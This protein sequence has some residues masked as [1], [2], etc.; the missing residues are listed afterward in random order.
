MRSSSVFALAVL[1]FAAPA[2]AQ[3]V[4]VLEIDG[5]PQGKLR[6]QIENALKLAAVVELVPLKTYRDAAAKKKVRLSLAMSPAGVARVSRVVK[7]DAAVGGE[8]TD[9]TYKVLISDR[10][11][12][13]LWTKELPV[14]KGVLSDDFAN[15]LARAIAA[16][17]EQGAARTTGG[18]EETNGGGEEQA[19][20][21]LTKTD[22]AGEAG[23]A[24]GGTS[25]GASDTGSG[26][27]GEERDSDL[28]DPNRRKQ[29][30]RVP[31]K[32][33]R[34]SLAGT[35]TWRSQCLRPGVTNCKEYDLAQVPPTGISIDFTATVPYLGLSIGAELFPLALLDNRILQGFGLLVGFMYGQS[36][37][38][39]VEESSQGQSAGQTVKSDDLAFSMQLAWRYHFQMGYGDP[40]PVGWVGLRGGTQSRS[41]LIDPTAGTSLPSSDR[42]FPTGLGFAQFGIDAS[43]PLN[44]YIRLEAAFSY[45]VNPRPAAEQI[46]GYG[47]LN[48]PTGGATATGFGIEAGVAGELWG[49]LGYTLRWRAMSFADRYYGQGQKW[50][51]CNEQQCGGV[52]EESFHS[53]LWGVTASF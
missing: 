49:P 45:Y 36:Q 15:K 25:T 13:Q 10:A 41:F 19:G 22:G 11:G 34:F 24:T 17:A 29:G 16:A 18:T 31:V 2:M 4:V 53:I 42:V 28:E 21:D 1:L 7:L 52:G 23:V 38:R 9:S 5:D 48:D 12:E 33:V 39:I 35:T 51:V 8:V 20:L 44:K 40:Q 50:T 6:N 37:T 32:L 46:V 3:K 30:K 26:I 27:I 43:I 47:N 14:K